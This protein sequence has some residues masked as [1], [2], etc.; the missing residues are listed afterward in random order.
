[1]LTN[2]NVLVSLTGSRRL[3]TASTY[4][5]PFSMA[6]KR[7]NLQPEK[8]LKTDS[9]EKQNRL[10]TAKTQPELFNLEKSKLTTD[11]SVEKSKLTADSSMEKSKLTA[12]LN[13][14][15]GFKVSKDHHATIPEPHQSILE[16]RKAKPEMYKLGRSFEKNSECS[17]HSMEPFRV[18]QDSLRHG[19]EAFRMDDIAQDNFRV[20][21]DF[22]KDVPNAFKMGQTACKG[23]KDTKVETRD[24]GDTPYYSE[25][26]GR[27]RFDVGD[28]WYVGLF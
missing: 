14:L 27:P 13:K 22:F 12:D 18:S 10:M 17:S 19:R 9:H 7:R 28:A 24:H 2:V 21:N 20:S 15:D 6:T 4:N 11:F 26:E 5:T 25:L 23:S 1:M 16:P 3:H 8:D